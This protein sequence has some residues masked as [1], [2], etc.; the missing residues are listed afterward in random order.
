M[1]NAV[2][3]ILRFSRTLATIKPFCTA[4]NGG[5]T[6]VTNNV[7]EGSSTIVDTLLE[8]NKRAVAAIKQKD[9]N[10]FNEISPQK[11]KFLYFG[12]SDARIAADTLLGLKPGEVFVHR[13]LGNCVPGNDLNALSVLEF[14]VS[15]LDVKH[16]I[17]GG[18]YDCGAVRAAMSNK[19]HGLMENWF[20]GI[21]DV[22][23]LHCEELDAIEDLETRHRRFVEL[24]VLEQCLTL[25][26]TSV[27]QAKRLKTYQDETIPFSYPKIHGVTF[28]PANGL[29]KRLPLD[30]KKLIREYQHVYDLYD[31]PEKIGKPRTS[32]KLSQDLNTS[33][34]G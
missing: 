2:S 3:G 33:E 27:V 1:V 19:E 26:K 4:H 29:L 7:K 5:N 23:R 8:R 20:R 25:F 24:N 6:N 21:R 9:P 31:E 30:F 15:V 14:A 18:H 22:Y 11:P 32:D 10:F 12:C 34:T 28:D 13:N 17:V 16:I